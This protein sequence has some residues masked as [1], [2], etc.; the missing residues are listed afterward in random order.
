MRGRGLSM[1]TALYRPPPALTP[2]LSQGEREKGKNPDL[3][4]HQ[5]PHALGFHVLALAARDE[6]AALHH[7]VVVGQLCAKS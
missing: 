2:A 5:L 4:R 7:Q 1:D 6:L 3:N